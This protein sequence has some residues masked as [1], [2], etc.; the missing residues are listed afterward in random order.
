[1]RTLL[2]FKIL[3]I[4]KGKLS[5]AGLV[6]LLALVLLLVVVG[7]GLW[8]VGISLFQRSNKAQKISGVLV[9]TIATA[10]S[11]G[12]SWLGY[13]EFTEIMELF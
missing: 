6:K 12:V 7:A 1:M 2:L 13:W 4:Q 9:L 8:Q 10:Y 3:L 5:Y 11:L